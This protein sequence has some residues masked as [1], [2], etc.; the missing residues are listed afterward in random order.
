MPYQ[1]IVHTA[2]LQL[3]VF[4]QIYLNDLPLFSAPMLGPYSQSH[5][6]NHLLVPGK[7]TLA[8][9]VH[10]APAFV[11]PGPRKEPAEASAPPTP[12]PTASADG[13]PPRHPLAMGKGESMQFALSRLVDASV[14]PM[15][16]DVLHRWIFPAVTQDLPPERQRV[17]CYWETSF[18]LGYPVFE[19]AFVHAPYARFDCRGSPEL[20]RAVADVHEA[21][22]SGDV[23]RLIELMSLDEQENELCYGAE[24]G[25]T[26]ADQRKAHEQW[27]ARGIAMDP[28]EPAKLHFAS[29]RAG[30]VAHVTRVDGRPVLSGRLRDDP[31][32]EIQGN[33][34][35]T[36]HEGKWRVT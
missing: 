13:E 33:I 23:E 32:R 31:S 14:T 10:G 30:Q 35:L 7:N 11:P 20:H 36:Q 18:E 9:E 4:A 17:P 34:L 8:F 15:A 26:V 28:L 22:V 2:N 1:L 16:I 29:R 3:G 5:R 21:F 25:T 6:I 27:F 12:P 24:P 19:R